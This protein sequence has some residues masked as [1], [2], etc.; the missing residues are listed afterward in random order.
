MDL[1]KLTRKIMQ[2]ASTKVINTLLLSNKTLR[3]I[4]IVSNTEWKYYCFIALSL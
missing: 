4:P 3:F 1:I 2:L